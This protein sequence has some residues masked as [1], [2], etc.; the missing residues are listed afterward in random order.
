MREKSDDITGGLGV[1]E[2][3]GAYVNCNWERRSKRSLCRSHEKHT[4]PSQI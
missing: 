4:Q 3:G 2:N 1:R